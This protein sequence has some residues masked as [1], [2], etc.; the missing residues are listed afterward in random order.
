KSAHDSFMMST[1][2]GAPCTCAGSLFCTA[3]CASACA[4]YPL[5]LARREEAVMDRKLATKPFACIVERGSQAEAAQPSAEY[6]E[7][8]LKT[9]PNA[10]PPAK[11]ARPTTKRFLEALRRKYRTLLS[12]PAK[13]AMK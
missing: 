12:E 11:E 2:F 5:G 8:W 10:T 6:S 13:R 3:A 9:R 1:T 7:G 4:E